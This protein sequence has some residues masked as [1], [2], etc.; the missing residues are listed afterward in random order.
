MART[1][2]SILRAQ[3][4]LRKLSPVS[5]IDIGSNSVRLVVYEGLSRSPTPLFNE[6]IL[7]G[8]GAHIASTGR[9]DEDGVERA[10]DALRRFRVL[11]EQAGADE[12]YTLATAAA[13]EAENGPD[14]VKR[15]KK[16]LGGKIH[17]LTGEEEAKFAAYG[18][19]CGF[20]KPKG[21]SADMG[22][23]SVEFTAIDG[24]PTGVGLTLPLGG[25][26]LQDESGDSVSEAKKL[27]KAALKGNQV[28]QSAQGETFYAVG[29]TWRALGR[30]HMARCDYP[31][32]V[33]HDYEISVE[34]ATKLCKRLTKGFGAAV[35][36]IEHVSTNRRILLPF[37]AALLLEIMKIMKPTRIVFSALGVR[38]G[39]LYSL[40]PDKVKKADPLISS[41]EE[42]AVLRAR[43]PRHAREM[44]KWSRNAF[45]TFGIKETG[46]ESRYRKAA[47]LTADI[48]WRSHPDYRGDQALN[49][50]SHANFVGVSHAGRAYMALANYYRHEGLMDDEL[51]PEIRS[52][53]P[54]RIAEH[55][56]LL[57][58]LFR[59]GWLVSA[60]MPGVLPKM[61]F[62]KTEDG[63]ALTVPEDL[64]DFEGERL[65]RRING[66]SSV[67]G[68]PVSWE[69]RKGE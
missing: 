49:I 11:S 25:L 26:R 32:H 46:R 67:L 58:A 17:V 57:G 52:I 40:L 22:G 62:R 48:T 69:V 16:I 38:E 35:R 68:K 18:I 29:G 53:A 8:L 20:L 43:S 39:Y 44:V 15:A 56:K 37:G 66:L 13:R 9:L 33:M 6:K 31:L 3:G 27:I 61:G 41:A 24:V 12:I 59:V 14:F 19:T 63:F 4:R 55:A 42:M 65:Q 23:G 60:A 30:L 50:I 54:D 64:A 21:V 36:G 10:L 28:L 2:K 1:L 47:C 7:C 34:E 51:A 45:K 5:I